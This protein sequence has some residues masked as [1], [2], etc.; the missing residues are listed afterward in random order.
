M[1]EDI[2]LI[3]V[4]AFA[5]IAIVI[6][7]IYICYFIDWKNIN[8]ISLIISIIFFFC[9]VFLNCIITLDYFI[10]TE[11]LKN[12]Y[13]LAIKIISNFYFISIVLIV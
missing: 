8:V 12:D 11:D 7:A 9:F 2:S 10:S 13:E 1:N 4:C 5:I 3:L 6:T